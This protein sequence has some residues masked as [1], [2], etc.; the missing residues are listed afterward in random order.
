VEK[1]PSTTR[2]VVQVAGSVSTIQHDMQ[3]SVQG[4]GID[5]HGV[6]EP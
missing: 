3:P 5:S 6:A 1:A 2:M 4:A